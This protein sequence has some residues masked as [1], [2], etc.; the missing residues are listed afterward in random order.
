[1]PADSKTSKTSNSR[2]FYLKEHN[3]FKYPSGTSDKFTKETF[4]P[5][6]PDPPYQR[7]FYTE[8]SIRCVGDLPADAQ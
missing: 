1:M 2:K 7:P 3:L 6:V 5:T 8:L 4:G